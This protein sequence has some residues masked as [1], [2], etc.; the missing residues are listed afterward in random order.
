MPPFSS[1]Q[2]VVSCSSSRDS[3]CSRI[4]RSILDTSQRSVTLLRS[5][6][7]CNLRFPPSSWPFLPGRARRPQRLLET[8]RDTDT[9][10]ALVP[11][12]I[13]KGQAE[14]Q[15]ASARALRR[16]WFKRAKCTAPIAGEFQSPA[17]ICVLHASR[18]LCANSCAILTFPSARRTQDERTQG[19]ESDH[20][21]LVAR[22]PRHQRILW[23]NLENRRVG[24]TTTPT[25]HAPTEPPNQRGCAV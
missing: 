24:R 17:A 1:L 11:A 3:A 16:G 25:P 8:H 23:P 19:F 12:A 14:Q 6:P 20:Q 15:L 4:L 13:T 21:P 22:P 5:H 9:L 7:Q 10:P 18:C 2:H